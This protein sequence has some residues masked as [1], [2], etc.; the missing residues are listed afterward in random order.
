MKPRPDA[1]YHLQVFLHSTE[2]GGDTAQF[3]QGIYGLRLNHAV[4][5]C[6]CP[7]YDTGTYGFPTDL[8]R[9]SYL[10]DVGDIHSTDEARALSVV[11]GGEL[12]L[13]ENDEHAGQLLRVT[14]PEGRDPALPPLPTPVLESHY[15]YCLTH[16][17]YVHYAAE[18]E[19]I[20]GREFD[21]SKL[22]DQPMSY[23]RLDT[24]RHYSLVTRVQ[25]LLTA[26]PDILSAPARELLAL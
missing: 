8:G 12:I 9:L 15:L 19:A 20:L 4:T 3:Y 22:E 6:L 17:E 7:A 24:L 11:N 10:Q 13:L 26:H 2:N 5:L 23:N 21:G 1:N 18:V 14:Y 25:E 16:A